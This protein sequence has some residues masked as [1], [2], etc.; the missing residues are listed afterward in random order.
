[1]FQNDSAQHR[2]QRINK[3]GR[4][5]NSSDLGRTFQRLLHTNT[6]ARIIAP[7]GTF[8]QGGCLILARALTRLEPDQVTLWVTIRADTGTTDHIAARW[9][10]S[11]LDG[12]GA[13]TVED[14]IQKMQRCEGA[15]VSHLAPLETVELHPDIVGDRH[16]ELELSLWLQSKLSLSAR[17]DF[18]GVARFDTGGEFSLNAAL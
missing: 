6:A 16:V 2:L 17:A 10:D 4:V 1:M 15:R 12:D 9:R 14:L 5:L 18:R 8:M 11:Y 13:G 7:H 3:N